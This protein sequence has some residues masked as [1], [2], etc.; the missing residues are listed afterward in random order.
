MQKLKI[1]MLLFPELTALD[2]IGP[3]DVFVKA[4]C[5]EVI[6]VG[7][8]TDL[9][10]A[11]GGVLFK[12]SVAF[13]ECPQ[14]DI[15]FV[16]GGKGINALL[17][18]PSVLNFLQQQGRNAKYITSVCTGSLVLAAAG[19]LEGYEATTHWRSL[20]L[21]KMFGVTVIENRVVKDRN[22]ITAAG[23][24]A[25]IDFGLKLTAL[26]GGEELAKII[27]L[28]LEYHPEPPFRA[29]SPQ[30]AG[31]PVLLRAKELTQPIFNLRKNIISKLLRQ[32]LPE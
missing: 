8:T 27:Q 9:L 7:E 29:G 4:P 31:L 6:T 12:P 15:L 22:R 3:Y 24:S 10:Q 32:Q 2:F 16:P 23:V 11:E 14:L 19:L 30:T 1:G 26:I 28:Q 21:L 5:F 20:E 17:T 13:D 18:N 25:G